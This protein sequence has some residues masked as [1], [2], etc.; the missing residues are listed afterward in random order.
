MGVLS[1]WQVVKEFPRYS[2][3]DE[4]RIRVDDTLSLKRPS[5]TARGHLIVG[6]NKDGVRSTRSLAKLVCEAFVQ[7]PNEYFDTT[8]HL[9]GDLSNCCAENLMWRPKW[10]ADKYRRQFT[11]DRIR[12]APIRNRVTGEVFEDV[13]PMAISR[14]LLYMDVIVAAQNGSHVF[15]S[16][17]FYD[18]NV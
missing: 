16:M 1:D 8:I 11:F 6:L 2:I 14:G 12:H 5:K 3:S 18:W 15:P 9:D 17:E 4:G 10:F 7:K 13:W